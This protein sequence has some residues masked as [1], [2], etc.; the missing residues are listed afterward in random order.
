MLGREVREEMRRFTL[1]H[2]DLVS[3]FYRTNN[4]RASSLLL[5]FILFSVIIYKSLLTCNP[6]L[7]SVFFLH[8]SSIAACP[9]KRQTRRCFS[10]KRPISLAVSPAD[11]KRKPLSLTTDI[12]V[13]AKL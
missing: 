4:Y 7:L 12:Q 2:G 3:D 10:R 5:P 1:K 6:S 11:R 8:S 13:Q 9:Q